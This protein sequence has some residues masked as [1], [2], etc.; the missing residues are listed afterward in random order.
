MS[1]HDNDQGRSCGASAGRASGRMQTSRLLSTMQLLLVSITAAPLFTAT[2]FIVKQPL[3]ANNERAI[4][5]ITASA[6]TILLLGFYLLSRVIQPFIDV[7]TQIHPAYHLDGWQA[8]EINSASEAGRIAT[9]WNTMVASL[10]DSRRELLATKEHL[11]LKYTVLLDQRQML[12]RVL[13]ETGL[14]VVAVDRDLTIVYC[15][16]MAAQLLRFSENQLQN[17]AISEVLPS[18]KDSLCSRPFEDLEA[19]RTT[20]LSIGHDKDIVWIEVVASGQVSDELT[21][22]TIRDVT[23]ERLRSEEHDAF[24]AHSVHDLRGPL[25]N[26][27]SYAEVV[28]DGIFEDSQIIPEFLN[29]VFC[30][31][32]ELNQLLSNVL[33]MS[34]VRMGQSALCK[35]KADVGE[36]INSVLH[37]FTNSAR[38]DGISLN[39]KIPSDLDELEVD[40][41]MISLVLENLLRNTFKSTE[42]GGTLEL[43]AEQTEEDIR[44]H[45]SGMSCSM[46]PEDTPNL[47]EMPSL[48]RASLMERRK[49]E[50]G[51]PLSQQIAMLHNG[52]LNVNSSVDNGTVFTLVLPIAKE[53]QQ[54]VSL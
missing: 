23:E 53:A 1:R 41:G 33:Y 44:I 24:I 50:F 19:Q 11:R 29:V 18:L 47:F 46:S 16:R 42:A 49:I 25:T 37:E 4:F 17:K 30:E 21:I 3:Q 38:A 14:G 43:S 48:N 20:T 39:T 6:G 54:H 27:L 22:L 7:S 12:E 15:N 31:G 2:L 9:M 5:I 13:N 32:R 8:V 10:T 28:S 36:L 52:N 40:Q 51:L 35:T 45:V 26:I 34:R